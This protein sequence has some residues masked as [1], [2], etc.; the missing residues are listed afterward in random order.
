[1]LSY[2][3]TEKFKLEYSVSNA[4]KLCAKNNITVLDVK[5]LGANECEVTVNT[6]DRKAFCKCFK[7]KKIRINYAL[8]LGIVFCFIFIAGII[9][10]NNYVLKIKI[11][12]DSNQIEA[13]AKEIV[14]S[15]VKI[16]SK[17]SDI[18]LAEIKNRLLEETQISLCDVK[19]VGLVLYVTVKENVAIPEGQFSPIVSSVDGVVQ[20]VNLT[21]GTA[22]VEKGSYVKKGDILIAP[23][24]VID[25]YVVPSRALGQV[26]ILAFSQKSEVFL[27]NQIE[28]QQTGRVFDKKYFTFLGNVVK[29]NNSDVNFLTYEKLRSTK[30]IKVGFI[31]IDVVTE[32]FFETKA[33]NVKIN[34]NDV[35]DMEQ[36]RVL[37][38]LKSEVYTQTVF[39]ENVQYKQMSSGVY[40]IVATV[41]Y[42]VT[43]N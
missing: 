34:F 14:E 1:M 22:I 16:A 2:A 36:A 23:E 43:I 15:K 11:D 40:Q 42:L 6:S 13:L 18:N 7:I 10:T 39:S 28:Y 33:V 37:E 32:R 17:K 31:P 3:K 25:N 29:L 4:L 24:M 8:I 27:E 41:Q 30:K 19:F 26:V 5:R 12:A 35:K 21:S 20:S 9:F 38:E